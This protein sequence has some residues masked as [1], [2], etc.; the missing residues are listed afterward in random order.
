LSSEY[1][2]GVFDV[3]GE[4]HFESPLF[5][6]LCGHDINHSEVPRKQ[7]I[8]AINLWGERLAMAMLRDRQMIP[9]ENR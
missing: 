6:S 7:A 2:D 9:G 1:A 8:K 3:D 4:N 5:R